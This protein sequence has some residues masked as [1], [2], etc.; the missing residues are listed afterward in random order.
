MSA[1]RTLLQQVPFPFLAQRKPTEPFG[2]TSRRKTRPRRW[3]SIP[4]CCF[5]SCRPGRGAQVGGRDVALLMLAQGSPASQVGCTC[6][7]ILDRASACRWK[8]SFS[9]TWPMPGR[10][11]SRCPASPDPEVGALHVSAC[12]APSHD[13]GALSGSRWRSGVRRAGHRQVG[14]GDDQESSCTSRPLP[15]RRS[16]RPRSAGW[17]PAVRISSRRRNRR[18]RR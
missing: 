8:N 12:P 18:R 13:L 1:G 4:G 11:P 14:A 5:R 6:A 16:A 7:C 3:S 9:A 2:T 10:R 15:A 17:R